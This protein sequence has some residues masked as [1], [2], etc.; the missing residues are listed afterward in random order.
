MNTIELRGP[1]INTMQKNGTAVQKNG[2][3]MSMGGGCRH[4]ISA[5][6]G[7]RALPSVRGMAGQPVAPATLTR[8]VTPARSRPVA[9]GPRG[10]MSCIPIE[11]KSA[12]RRSFDDESPQHHGN[13][14]RRSVSTERRLTNRRNL[15]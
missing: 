7:D 2:T 5:P 13:A 15:A 8:L 4:A 14:P 10:Q 11:R 1:R 9:D 3:P 6:A 12:L